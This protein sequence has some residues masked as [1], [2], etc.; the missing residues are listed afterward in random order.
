MSGRRLTPEQAARV[1]RAVGQVAKLADKMATKLPGLSRDD[2]RS[3]GHEALV[4]AA[5]RF[6]PEQGVPFAAY[7]H[8]RVRGAMIDAARRN[9]PAARRHSRALRALQASQSVL[10]GAAEQHTPSD[11]PERRTLEERV[12][13]AAELVAQTTAAVMLTRLRPVDPETVSARD[14][15]D[16]ETRLDDQRLQ[17]RLQGAL[18]D[19]SSEEREIVEALYVQGQ[20]MH[21][22]AAQHGISVS[23]VSRHHAKLLRKLA[24][25]LRRRRKS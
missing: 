13:A 5:L 9:H 19:C 24:V 21:D 7:A 25:T 22:F 2:L 20:S 10:E 18:D 1:E 8:Y 4:K 15:D 6:D 11:T 14:G 12:K 23:T 3:A 17:G 16:A